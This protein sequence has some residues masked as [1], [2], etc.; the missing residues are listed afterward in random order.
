MTK[1]IVN[2]GSVKNYP[3]KATKF[4]SELVKGKGETPKV[5]LCFFAQPREEWENRFEKDRIELKKF[6]ENNPI[7]EMAGPDLFEKQLKECDAIYIHG[8]DDYLVQYW[9]KQF[10]LPNIWNDKVVATGSASSNAL[11][12]QFWTGDWRKCM[13]GLGVLPIKFLAHF[14]S[15]YGISDPRGPIN[16][17]KAYKELENYSDKT[18]PIYALEE[19]DYK[20]FE[21]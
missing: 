19:G 5:L 17:E 8:G 2:S 10:D 12:K 20:I 18:L 15:N 6:F 7:F 11:S 1:Y 14:K 13:D 3:E 9:L 16:W 4:F 21:L